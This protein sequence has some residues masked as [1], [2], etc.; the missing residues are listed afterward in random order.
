MSSHFGEV[1]PNIDAMPGT[2]QVDD[3]PH[4]KDYC[5]RV[6]SFL[7]NRPEIV[8]GAAEANQDMVAAHN[9]YGAFII[10]GLGV[11]AMVVALGGVVI[12]PEHINGKK[13]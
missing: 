1:P 11:A 5:K 13:K 6:I 12:L 2:I 4:P 10:L 7:R 9:S 3:D 8:S